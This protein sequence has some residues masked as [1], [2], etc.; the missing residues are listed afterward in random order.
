MACLRGLN[1]PVI[2]PKED[3]LAH[4][5]KGLLYYKND[6]H[7]SDLGAYYGYVALVTALQKTYPNL[8]SVPESN[9]HMQNIV[10]KD[11]DLARMLNLEIPEYDTLQYTVPQIIKSTAT[12]VEK[13]PE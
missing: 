11:K 2:Y 5:D 1:I 3:L 6:T 10:N 7:W 8:K 13:Y 4:K 12:V 9:I